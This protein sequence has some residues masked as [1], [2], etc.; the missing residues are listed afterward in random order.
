MLTISSTIYITVLR[1]VNLTFTFSDPSLLFPKIS[2]LSTSVECS[3][4]FHP[5]L[6][7]LF[8]GKTNKHM[9]LVERGQLKPDDT[10][11]FRVCCKC[12]LFPMSVGSYLAAE[13]ID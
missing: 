1:V 7:P 9:S 3:Y 12:D 6:S 11:S 8:F 13:T 2:L 10:Y 5:S 4:N